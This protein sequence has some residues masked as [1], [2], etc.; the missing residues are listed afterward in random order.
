[1]RSWPPPGR[2]CLGRALSGRCGRP[3]PWV[4]WRRFP[5][6]RRRSLGR[7]RTRVSAARR[8]FLSAAAVC[9]S[10]KWGDASAGAGAARRPR[11]S[12]TVRGGQ[13]GGV[14][15]T[16]RSGR[17]RPESRSCQTRGCRVGGA[18]LAPRASSRPG[19]RGVCPPFCAGQSGGD[20]RE[21]CGQS[22]PRSQ[23][24]LALHPD[25]TTSLAAVKP[26]KVTSP[27]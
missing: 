9:L 26:R 3:R 4:S 27:L 2:K 23:A 13:G 7:R 17:R 25:S 5:R 14:G 18:R 6:S 8:A 16:T 21:Q 24:D 12:C 10:V 15:P 20:P 22:G 1:M 11:G 19:S